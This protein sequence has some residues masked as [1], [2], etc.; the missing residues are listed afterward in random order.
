[1]LVLA[2]D[3]GCAESAYALVGEDL[4][5]IRFGKIANDGMR[6]EIR[7]I[8]SVYEQVETVIEMVSS[9][10]MPVGREVFETCL[11]IG[12]FYETARYPKL[13]YRAD[14]K[15]H[16]CGMAR[17]KDSNIRMA[18]IDR[19]AKHDLKTGKGT[20]KKP[21]H[22]Y[23]FKADVWQAYA[24]AVTRIDQIQRPRSGER[25]VAKHE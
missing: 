7:R 16:I 3:P 21:D 18:L 25:E 17:A 8:D 5:P 24:L 22:F 2:I 14:V 13:M 9:Y 19:F 11:E 4:K 10:G 23:G 1:M 15:L 20:K 6:N 12:R